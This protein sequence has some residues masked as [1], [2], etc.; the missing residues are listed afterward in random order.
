ML[1]TSCST[2]GRIIA[3]QTHAVCVV[4]DAGWSSCSQF[5][6]LQ[7]QHKAAWTTLLFKSTVFMRERRPVTCHPLILLFLLS[8]LWSSAEI[9]Y[10]L[11][12][13][14]WTLVHALVPFPN[15]KTHINTHALSCFVMVD[16]FPSRPRWMFV[17]TAAVC[18]SLGSYI[19][20]QQPFPL[21]WVSVR[22]STLT[23]S[24]R[25]SVRV[26]SRNPAPGRFYASRCWLALSMDSLDF[27]TFFSPEF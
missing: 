9:N 5:V 7:M 26:S 22:V 13:S 27:V 20:A 16:A 24:V 15:T 3:F 6:F 21:V 23:W 1:N 12:C 19:T 4:L 25:A 8:C 2:R 18:Y 10:S 11:K 14:V 17:R